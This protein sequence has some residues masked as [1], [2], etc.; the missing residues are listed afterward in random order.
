VWADGEPLEYD[1]WMAGN[2]Q[3]PGGPAP[4]GFACDDG[5]GADFVLQRNGNWYSH[6]AYGNWP[7][8]PPQKGAP[9]AHAPGCFDN[10]KPFVCS[11]PAAPPHANGGRMYGC[12][13]GH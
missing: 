9:A 10:I 6:P 8:D 1:S 5:R 4:Q 11:K 13:D 3:N 12:I 7:S 2:P